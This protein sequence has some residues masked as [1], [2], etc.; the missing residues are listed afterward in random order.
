[1]EANPAIWQQ[2]TPQVQKF[3]V[4]LLDWGYGSGAATRA[5]D[6]ALHKSSAL[7][8]QVLELLEAINASL[9]DGK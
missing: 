9:H 7:R 2:K 1:M 3:R 4:D 6:Y 8:E 5:L